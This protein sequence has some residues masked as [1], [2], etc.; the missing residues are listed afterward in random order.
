MKKR[1]IAFL[2]AVLMLASLCGCF[3][4]GG[5]GGDGNGDGNGDGGSVVDPDAN[6]PGIG[7]GEGIEGPRIPW[8]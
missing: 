2:L 4:F 6:L 8:N 5:N 7:D 1:I 3:D